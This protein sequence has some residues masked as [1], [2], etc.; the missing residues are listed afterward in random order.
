[1]SAD[2]GAFT[3]PPPP[4]PPYQP[5]RRTSN[6]LIIAV[7]IVVAAAVVAGVGVLAVVVGRA[8]A[9]TAAHAVTSAN[10]SPA[11][12]L[13]ATSGAVVF[14]DDFH[15]S[16]S[17]WSTATLPSGTVLSYKGGKYVILAKGDL[18]HYAESPYQQARRQLTAS[19]TGTQSDGAPDGAGFGVTCR[20]GLGAQQVRYQF[21]V[22]TGG[23]FFVEAGTGADS[24]TTIPAIL[25]QGT[26]P[27]SPGSASIT[28]VGACMS[29]TDGKTTR[30]VL[31]VNG[32][33]VA[34]LTDVQNLSGNGWLSGID[35]ASRGTSPSTVTVTRFEERDPAS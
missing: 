4:P 21:L 24:S 25:K 13:Q 30:L 1:M 2:Y 9:G 28:V 18:H 19:V 22:L 34:D 3:P 31:F 11:G 35:V 32:T 10:P 26:S 17:G 20:R 29:E 15:E 8:R 27:V 16:S 14:S 23:Q 7:A 12:P 5:P 6:G 33:S